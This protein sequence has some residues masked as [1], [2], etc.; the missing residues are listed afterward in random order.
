[1]SE[2]IYIV[3]VPFDYGERH[4]KQGDLFVPG[5]GRSDD[6]ICQHL[7]TEKRVN[8]ATAKDHEPKG[9]RKED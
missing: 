3:R 2:V 7:C 6:Q 4:F 1:M 9:K 5:N 8:Q